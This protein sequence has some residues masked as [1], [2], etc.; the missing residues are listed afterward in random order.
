MNGNRCAPR[1]GV[2]EVLLER[3]GRLGRR[4]IRDR[5]R[6][7][8]TTVEFAHGRLLSSVPG[9]PWVTAGDE[10]ATFRQEPQVTDE[11]QLAA[12]SAAFERAMRV[13][14]LRE[15]KLPIDVRRNQPSRNPAR[16]AA[17]RRATSSG[18]RVKCSRPAPLTVTARPLYAL[19]KRVPRVRS[20]RRR[21]RYDRAPSPPRDRPGT[22]SCPPRRGSD[23]RPHRS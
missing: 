2:T 19:A 22:S 16:T 20:R 12:C 1:A 5:G 14:G 13:R 3:R 8:E 6:V 10:A 21:R 4:G 17:A 9:L 11:Q 23:R 7:E 18:V 15:W